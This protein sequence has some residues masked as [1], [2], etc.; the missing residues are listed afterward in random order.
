MANEKV[1]LSLKSFITRASVLF[2]FLI[3]MENSLINSALG[4]ITLAFPDADPTEISMIST[5][6]QLLMMIFAFFIVPF[7]ITRI[8]KKTLVMFSLVC[9]VFGGVGGAFINDSIFQLLLMRSFI[10]IGAGISAPMCGAIINDLYSGTERNT[11]LG[12]ANGVCSLIGIVLTMIAGWLASIKWEYTFFAYAFFLI[13][14]VMEAFFLPSIPAPKRVRRTESAAEDEKKHKLRG[15]AL[16]K[17]IFI[18]LYGGS[19]VALSMQTM[20]KI[21]I[22]IQEEELGTPVLAA[23]AMSFT[24]AGMVA[25]GFTFGLLH[26]YLRRSM[27]VIGPILGLVGAFLCGYATSP[28]QLLLASVFAGLG[29][30]INMPLMQVKTFS[31]APKSTGAVFNSIL[32]GVMTGVTFPAGYLEKIFGVFVEPTARNIIIM[33]GWGYLVFTVITIIYIIWSPFKNLPPVLED[34]PESALN[35]V[36]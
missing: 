17:F 22:F 5:Y 35:E 30:G 11:M 36:S 3:G 25:M 33:S 14:V 26:K 18:L 20:L 21:A 31:L 9:Y 24:M 13:V 29:G 1:D 23:S 15:M 10:G 12:L 27:L 16:A 6:P 19:F 8:N 4:E 2:I 34:G 32:M 28:V 7:L